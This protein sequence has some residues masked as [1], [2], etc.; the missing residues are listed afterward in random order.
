MVSFSFA[1]ER[2]LLSFIQEQSA[3]FTS[4]F[5]FDKLFSLVCSIWSNNL[6]FWQTQKT[7]F[8]HQV[9]KIWQN[10]SCLF[11]YL[12]LFRI[13]P[14]VS[15]DNIFPLKR[16][17]KSTQKLSSLA[18]FSDFTHKNA[19]W[20]FCSLKLYRIQFSIELVS[21]EVYSYIEK[22]VFLIKSTKQMIFWW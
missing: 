7:S 17:F 9:F 13:L 10:F 12:K 21:S 20:K 11:H 3:I 18:V 5:C 8:F 2:T 15:K 4:T 14:N 16:S 6:K 22:T 19:L 1:L